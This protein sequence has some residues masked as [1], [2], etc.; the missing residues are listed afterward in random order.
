M[1]S[2]LDLYVIMIF[3]YFVLDMQ[4]W[5]YCKLLVWKR[6]QVINEGGKEHIPHTYIDLLKHPGWQVQNP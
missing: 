3:F 5:E 1:L 6:L 2:V 4:L